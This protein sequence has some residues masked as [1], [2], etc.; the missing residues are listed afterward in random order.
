MIALIR[1]ILQALERC[2]LHGLAFRAEDAWF[3]PED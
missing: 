1:R 3:G 2:L